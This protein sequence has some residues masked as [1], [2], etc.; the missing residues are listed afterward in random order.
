[1]Y[2]HFHIIWARV[3]THHFTQKS[4]GSGGE[5]EYDGSANNEE[6]K[7]VS[8]K[9][10]EQEAV[11]FSRHPHGCLADKPPISQGSERESFVPCKA[12]ASAADGCASGEETEAQ[13]SESKLHVKRQKM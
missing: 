12:V 5:N 13:G 2:V 9:V 10:E 1:M 6:D 4:D 8:G 3:E 11:S 7:L